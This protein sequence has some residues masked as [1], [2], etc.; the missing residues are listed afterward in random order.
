MRKATG[1][2]RPKGRDKR[3]AVFAGVA[4]LVLVA[5]TLGALNFKPTFDL[6]SAGIPSGAESEV[7]LT[8]LERGLPPG[9]T[10]PTQVYLHATSGVGAVA[11][12][13]VSNSPGT[14]CEPPARAGQHHDR[15]P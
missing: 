10:E 5:L 13:V 2:R 3:P 14:A 7:A 11:A 9:A 12:P 15:R 6:S 8:V 4:G 1:T